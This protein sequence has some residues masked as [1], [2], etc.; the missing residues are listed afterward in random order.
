[1]RTIIYAMGCFLVLAT[2][3]VSNGEAAPK[4]SRSVHVRKSMPLELCSNPVRWKYFA[5]FT[6]APP[7]PRQEDIL[8]TDTDVL[9]IVEPLFAH[10]PC[11]GAFETRLHRNGNTLTLNA[12]LILSGITATIYGPHEYLLPIGRLEPGTYSLVVNYLHTDALN[13]VEGAEAA[14]AFLDDPEGF[15]ADHGWQICTAEYICSSPIIRQTHEFTVVPEPTA[16]L[17]LSLGGLS[18]LRLRKT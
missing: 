12:Y 5:P 2:V 7:S 16:M 3:A 4:N 8:L 17:L 13:F 14:S 18:L 10:R 11:F 1:M 6:P 9:T 15:A